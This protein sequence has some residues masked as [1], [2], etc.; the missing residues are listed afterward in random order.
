[1]L[2]LVRGDGR[3]EGWERR[4]LVVVAANRSLRFSSCAPSAY[5]CHGQ[6][7]P[8]GLVSAC[9]SAGTLSGQKTSL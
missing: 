5:R 4:V 6:T 8:T 1:M 9:V 2:A 7:S 3:F